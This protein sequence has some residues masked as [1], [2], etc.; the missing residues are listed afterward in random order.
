MFVCFDLYV[1][2]TIPVKR[3]QINKIHKKKELEIVLMDSKRRLKKDLEKDLTWN[4]L[5]GN[6]FL[7]HYPL[8]LITDV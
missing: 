4:C 6:L 3:K 8:Y 5:K 2:C 7:G 1:V